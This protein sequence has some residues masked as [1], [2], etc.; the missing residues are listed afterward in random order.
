MGAQSPPAA[1]GRT[2]ERPSQL[3]QLVSWASVSLLAHFDKSTN[4]MHNR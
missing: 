3:W 1:G 2:A 4:D